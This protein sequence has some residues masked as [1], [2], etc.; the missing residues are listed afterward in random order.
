MNINIQDIYINWKPDVLL[1]L[2]R[3]A[4]QHFKKE[5]NYRLDDDI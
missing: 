4:S 1:I 2:I 3:L 5:D